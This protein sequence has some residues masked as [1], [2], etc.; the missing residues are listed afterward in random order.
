MRG[1]RPCRR[2]LVGATA[3][4]P[5]AERA[6]AVRRGESQP[7]QRAPRGSP[8]TACGINPGTGGLALIWTALLALSHLSDESESGRDRVGEAVI[9]LARDEVLG[10]EARADAH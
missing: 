1:P 3:R 10:D 5:V 7:G 6:W 9:V 4:S 8:A 2:S